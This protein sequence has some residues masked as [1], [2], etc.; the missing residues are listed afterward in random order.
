MRDASALWSVGYASSAELV[1]AACDLLVTGHDGPNLSMLAGVAARVLA[2]ALEPLDLA[3]WAHTA[4]GHGTPA[5]A[6]HLVELDD[7]YD[8]LEYTDMTEQDLNIEILGEARRIV[9]P[10]PFVEA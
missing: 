2:G 7:V 3:T 1:D 4:F 5:L 8:T 9:G 6:E 10:H